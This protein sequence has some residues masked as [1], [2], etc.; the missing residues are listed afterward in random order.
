MP[1]PP[2]KGLSLKIA[3]AGLAPLLLTACLFNDQSDPGRPA[4]R[5]DFSRLDSLEN[6]LARWYAIP[7]DKCLIGMTFAFTSIDYQSEVDSNVA[8]FGR[9]SGRLPMLAGAYFDLSSQ[10]KNL[11]TVLNAAHAQGI[12]PYVTL[13]PKDWDEP[14][15]A[16]QKTF[17]PL[18]N[19]GLFDA[20][21]KELAAVVKDFGFPI[22]LRFAHEMNGDWYPYSGSFIGGGRDGDGDGVADGPQA[23]IAAWRHAHDLFAT[24]GADQVVWVFCPN[25]ESFPDQAW[26]SPFSYYP[27]S[28]YVDLI[29]SDSYE[30][31]LQR[32]RNLDQVLAGFLDEMGW[33]WDAHSGDP[34]YALRAY[35]LG[36]FGTSRTGAE[37]KSDWYRNALGY[38]AGEPRL[39]FQVLYNGRNGSQDF[40]ITGIGAA[41]REAYAQGRFLSA[42][43]LI[44][45]PSPDP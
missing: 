37:D 3:F 15:L 33:F 6:P 31:P 11:R 1:H 19:A 42:P 9:E 8:R 29:A 44:R 7:R 34:D 22:L 12:I 25:G 36:E 10:G 24:E 14:D 20:K 5:F 32:R 17:I 38:I 28:R 2:G 45:L 30:S 4:T 26:N 16:Y 41:L 40:S 21:L 27:G 39:R 35:G 23:Y 18:I 13:D 43:S